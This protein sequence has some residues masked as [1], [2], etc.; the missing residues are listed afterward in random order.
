MRFNLRIFGFIDIDVVRIRSFEKY[1]NE[2]MLYRIIKIIFLL[3][4]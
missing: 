2:E 3:N 1:R 4:S